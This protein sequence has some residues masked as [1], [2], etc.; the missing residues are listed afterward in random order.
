MFNELVTKS[1]HVQ[2]IRPF[3]ALM[4]WLYLPYDQVSLREDKNFHHKVHIKLYGN[5]TSNFLTDLN[6]KQLC[7]LTSERPYGELNLGK[8]CS[9]LF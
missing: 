6:L 4:E 2:K 3:F 8:R 9:R 5:S 1:N 7:V